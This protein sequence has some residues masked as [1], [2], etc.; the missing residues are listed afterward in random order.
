M[1]V[2]EKIR[3]GGLIPQRARVMIA[4]SGGADSTALLCALHALQAELQLTLC[5]VHI[6]HGLRGAESQR[7]EDFCAALCDRLGIPLTVRA[8]DVRA[9]AAQTHCSVEL[10]ARNLRYRVFAEIGANWLIATAHTASDQTETVLLNLTR[11]T[12]LAGLCGIPRKRGNIIRPLLSVTREEILADLAAQGQDFVTDSSNDSDAHTR[13]RLRHRIVPLLLE[14]N[15]ALHRVI[16][17]T[18]QQL[19]TEQDYLAAQAEAAYQHAQTA[20]H[21]LSGLR[22]LHPA[23]RRRCIALFLDKHGIARSAALITA[24][25]SM[26][27]TD[28]KREIASGIYL[29]AADGILRLTHSVSVQ[30]ISAQPLQFGE[31]KVFSGKL[32]L[33][34]LI[35]DI[36]L[37]KN[38]N[39]HNKFTNTMLDYDKIIGAAVFRR[40]RRNDRISLPRRGFSSYARKLVQ[41]KVPQQHRA[42]L[43]CLADDAGLIWIERIGIAQRV[44]PDQN[45][46]RLLTL[47]VTAD[48]QDKE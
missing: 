35:T 16:G 33:A 11:G 25:E 38:E 45:T 13:N 8:V 43:H 29:S 41:D 28:G 47:T 24:A 30:E 42:T 37:M 26:L 32:C 9:E 44:A 2:V 1:S 18:A 7:D 12:G 6:N 5:A 20:P 4:L 19:C 39:I 27:E 21:T 46:I 15:P 48:H 23:I 22:Q 10:A 31:N 17:A 14:E 34:E 40:C 3:A 36:D